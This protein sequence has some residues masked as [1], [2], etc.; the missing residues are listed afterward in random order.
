MPIST[1]PMAPP[2]PPIDRSLGKLAPLFG[3]K[4]EELITKLQALGWSPQVTE[5]VRTNERQKWLYGLGRDY[6][7]IDRK[8]P[9]TNA[10]VAYKSWHFYGL[11]ID[12]IDREERWDAKSAFWADVGMCCSILGLEWGGRWAQ[13]DLPHVQWGKPM[14]KTPSEAAVKIFQKEGQKGV[15]KAVGAL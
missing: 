12:M 5:T 6:R 15:W 1:L 8:G 10:K 11:A 3:R 9:V 2:E 4:V 7:T 14:R 13:P